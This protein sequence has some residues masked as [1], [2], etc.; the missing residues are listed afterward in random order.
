MV[1]HIQ[2][3][4]VTDNALQDT[5]LDEAFTS[6]KGNGGGVLLQMLS[7][8]HMSRTLLAHNR[9]FRSGGHVLALLSMGRLFA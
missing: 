8:M 2:D 5:L 3:S 6:V 7:T 4:R 1:A 9:A